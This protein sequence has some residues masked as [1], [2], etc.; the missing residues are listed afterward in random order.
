MKLSK[1]AG[2]IVTLDELVDEIGVDALRYSLARYPADSPADARRRRDHQGLG[3]QPG[4]LRPVRP[5]PH[6]PDDRATPPTSA[7]SLP[8]DDFDPALLD[9]ELDGRPA[10]C[11]GRVPAGGGERRRAA[12]AA[13]RRALPR[14]HRVGLQQVVRHQGV[15]DAAAGRRAGHRRQRG[16]PGPGR[17]RPAPCSPTA[18]TCS[19]SPPPSGCERSCRPPTTSGWAHADGALRGPHWLREPADPNALVAAPVVA[20][21][22]AR[23][24]ASWSSAECRCPTWSREHGSPAYVLDEADFRARAA[25]LPRRLRRLRRLLRRQGVPLHHRRPLAGRG[26]ALPRRLL[27]RGADRRRAGRLPDGARI[28]FHGNNKTVA[29]LERAVELGRG[30]GHRRLLR[31]DRAAGRGRR[32]ARARTARA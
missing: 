1:R 8:G 18:S 5:R 32:R 15:P 25:R 3:R 21:G 30:S 10:A 11:A 28:G 14:G 12:R 26:R 9:H 22:R 2:T 19:A 17:T 23:P 20:H 16:A 7:W 27:G 29:E 24:T 13:P 6:L 4:L 31:R